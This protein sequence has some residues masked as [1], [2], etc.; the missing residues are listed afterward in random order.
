VGASGVA[1]ATGVPLIG[2]QGANLVIDGGAAV[3]GIAGSS[4]L[5]SFMEVY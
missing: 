1:L 5:V 2:T 3:Y 4:E